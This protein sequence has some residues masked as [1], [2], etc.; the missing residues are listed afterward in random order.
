MDLARPHSRR[1]IHFANIGY[2]QPGSGLWEDDAADAGFGANTAVAAGRKPND[3]V[4]VPRRRKME[5]YITHRR[6][7]HIPSRE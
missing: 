3:R 1:L 5:A 6:S 7:R 2:Y 4:I